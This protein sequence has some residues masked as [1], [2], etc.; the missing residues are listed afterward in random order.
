[1]IELTDNQIR[2]AIDAASAFTAWLDAKKAANSSQLRGSMFWK[3]QAG[4]IYLIRKDEAGRQHSLGP[5]GAETAAILAAFEH[6]KSEAKS[7]AKALGEVVATHAR[8]NRA[9]RIGRVPQIVVSVLNAIEARG[10]SEHFLVV[11]THALFA[12]AAAAGLQLR[13][14]ETATQDVDLLFDVRRH[15]QF[16]QAMRDGHDSLMDVIRTAD[17]S[18]ARRDDQL[19]TAVNNAGFEVDIIRRIARGGDPHPLRMSR[20]EDDFWAAQ[21]SMGETLLNG[22][23]MDQI[24]IATDGTMAKMRTIAPATFCRVK[25]ALAA[26]PDRDPAKA[27]RDAAQADLVESIIAQYLPQWRQREKPVSQRPSG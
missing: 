1:M 7:R 3:E 12:Y 9:L 17:K 20:Q 11:G 27:L 16:L 8:M 22:E 6:R 18:F 15:L 23:R 14:D 21:V 2:Q 24:V 4:R 26:M 19:Y 10:L 25:R 5:Q 13:P